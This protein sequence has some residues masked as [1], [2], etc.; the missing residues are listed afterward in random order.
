LL[1]DVHRAP[2]RREKTVSGDSF[3][4]VFAVCSA[5]SRLLTYIFYIN[6]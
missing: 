3:R 1:V 4:L 2:S 5:F 6:V